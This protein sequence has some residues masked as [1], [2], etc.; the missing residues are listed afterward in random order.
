M[1]EL[2]A[3]G[4]TLGGGRKSALFLSFKEAEALARII[5][6]LSQ[7]RG[8][9]EGTPPSA[10]GARPSSSNAHQTLAQKV[11]EQIRQA[12]V[13][14]LHPPGARLEETTLARTLGVSRTPVREALGQ[15]AS[16]GLVIYEPRKG[17]RVAPRPT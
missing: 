8:A 6:N 5:L 17:C 14:G 9:G 11:A 12:I 1:L 2:T 15:L 7:V 16:A 3:T 10:R 13:A 4:W